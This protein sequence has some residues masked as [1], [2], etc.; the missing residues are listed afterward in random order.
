MRLLSWSWSSGSDLQPYRVA[1]GS[2]E[3]VF[4]SLHVFVDLE[5]VHAH[6]PPGVLWGGGQ[7]E[8]D[9]PG[10]LQIGPYRTQSGA[11]STSLAQHLPVVCSRCR[12]DLSR[13]VPGL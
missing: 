13:V 6:V 8:Y 2:W 4:F 5:K 1:K 10:L 7:W 3:F 9:V 12:L 11:V